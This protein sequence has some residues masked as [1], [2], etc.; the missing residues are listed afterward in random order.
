MRKYWVF[1]I[2]KLRS[3]LPGMLK[4]CLNCSGESIVKKH[5]SIKCGLN[6]CDKSSVKSEKEYLCTANEDSQNLGVMLEWLKRHAWKAC[7]RQKRIGGFESPSL[8]KVNVCLIGSDNFFK[9]FQKG[10]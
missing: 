10:F 9:S 7:I 2:K 1:L 3:G 5:K 6:L 8:R 4:F